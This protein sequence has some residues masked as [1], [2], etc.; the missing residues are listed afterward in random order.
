MGGYVGVP[1]SVANS[2]WLWAIEQ[3]KIECWDGQFHKQEN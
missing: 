3:V 2:L 1:Q